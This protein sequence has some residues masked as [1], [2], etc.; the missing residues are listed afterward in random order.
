M[1]L[2]R[3]GERL[4]RLRTCPRD[5]ATINSIVNVDVHGFRLKIARLSLKIVK[6][7]F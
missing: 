1:R 3:I 6:A 5:A 2:S 7:S 4:L